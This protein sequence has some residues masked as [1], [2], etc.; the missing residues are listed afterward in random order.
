MPAIHYLS[1]V[2]RVDARIKY[3]PILEDMNEEQLR[4]ALKALVDGEQLENA[5]DLAMATYKFTQ[6]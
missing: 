5:M 2:D 6:K 1:Y 3:F 4:F